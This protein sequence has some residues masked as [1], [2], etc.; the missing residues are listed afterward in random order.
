MVREQKESGLT[1]RQWCADQG[2]TEHAFYYRLRRIRQAACTA[3]EQAQPV[4]LAEVPLAP[5]APVSSPA[6]LQID[7]IFYRISGG[8]EAGISIRRIFQPSAET[9][10]GRNGNQTGKPEHTMVQSCQTSVHEN[11]GEFDCSQLNEE[12]GCIHYA[13]RDANSSPVRQPHRLV[14]AYLPDRRPGWAVHRAP[15][16][17]QYRPSGCIFKRS[18]RRSA[19]RDPEAAGGECV[20]K[21]LQALVLEQDRTQCKKTQ[22]IQGLRREHELTMLFFAHSRLMQP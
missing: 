9:Y 17:R 11:H 20:P 10:K 14:G 16:L 18:E 12:V 15:R 19:G 1:V 13:K 4:Q 21:K 6:Q 5:A 2:V 22:E 7:P 8:S 3:L